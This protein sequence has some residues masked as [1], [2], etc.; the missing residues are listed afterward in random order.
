MTTGLQLALLG[1]ALVGLGLSLI[2]WRLLPADPDPVDVVHRYSPE[3]VRARTAAAGPTLQASTTPD[4]LGIWAIKRF[5]ASW[6]GKTPTKELALLRIPVH[7]FYGKKVLYGLTGLLISPVLS[8]FFVVLGW[9]IPILIP[10][11]GSI[12]LAVGL[13]LTPDLDV[14][15]DARHARAEFGRALGAYTDLV[16]L[17]RLGGSGSRQAMELAAEVGDSWVFQRIGEE[18]ARSRWSGLAPWDAL[19]ALSDELGLPELDDL[20][21]IM[22]LSKEGSQVYSNLRARSGALRSAMLN[23]ELSKA[24]ATGERMSMPM[25]LLGVVFM[26]ILVA[27]Q[28]L[29]VMGG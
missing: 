28:L 5:P 16:A 15:T 20:A 10:L 6:W 21:D 8:Y 9:S 19:N 27:P 12:L 24:N 22:R 2:V 25:S 13:F 4:R 23:E 14:R 7:R 17:E 1:G 3:G 11:I 26:A 18:L 29:R